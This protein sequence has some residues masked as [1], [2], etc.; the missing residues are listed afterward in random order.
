[1]FESRWLKCFKSELSDLEPKMHE[2]NNN[3]NND[4]DVD[5][6][7]VNIISVCGQSVYPTLSVF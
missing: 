6:D 4:V 3:N 2:C 1:M 7:V 5:N